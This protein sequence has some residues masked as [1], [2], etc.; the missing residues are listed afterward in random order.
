MHRYLR[1]LIPSVEGENKSGF[2]LLPMARPR[3]PWIDAREYSARKLADFFFN[4]HS[5][6]EHF[7]RC[8]WKVVLLLCTVG[9]CTSRRPEA[10]RRSADSNSESWSAKA[11]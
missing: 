8:C 2:Q 9:A 4:R 5:F 1:T 11:G 3:V 6:F 10:S 7:C